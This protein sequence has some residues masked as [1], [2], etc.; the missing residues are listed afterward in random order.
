MGNGFLVEIL[1]EKERETF[2]IGEY[3]PEKRSFAFRKI[4]AGAGLKII[5]EF[6]K[7]SPSA[8][9][10]NASAKIENF[11]EI[12]DEF[13]DAVSVLTDKK[14]FWGSVEYVKKA[15]EK[16]SL[17]IIAKDFY[18]SKNQILRAA[19]FGAD[20]VLLIAKILSDEKMRELYEVC[21]G[22]G[23]DAIFEVHDRGEVERI[24]KLNP[25]IIGIN[26]RNLEDF[27]IDGKTLEIAD[28]IPDGIFLIA[29]SGI[30]KPEDVKKIPA[31]FN[32]VL[33]GTAL[34]KAKN[35]G[36]FLKKARQNA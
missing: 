34:M 22:A 3:H 19:H 21:E 31:R 36:E 5:A 33:M 25:K 16:T 9:E 17:P 26:T 6:K 1:K 8:G 15:R 23:I 10:I 30:E 14:F 20:A 12:Y 7:A 13:A 32:A 27:S 11:I 29:E 18:V 24:L 4:F 2:L 35:P 28:E